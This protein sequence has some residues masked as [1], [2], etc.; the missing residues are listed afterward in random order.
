MKRLLV[1][2]EKDF[3][4][5]TYPDK[6]DLLI[7]DMYLS[8]PTEPSSETVFPLV[9]AKGV[10][11]TG[12]TLCCITKEKATEIGLVKTGEKTSSHAG[13]KNIVDVYKADLYL[14]KFKCY[15]KIDLAEFYPPEGKRFDVLIGMDILRDW[16]LSIKTRS[17]R[18]SFSLLHK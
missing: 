1:K 5:I 11:D 3:L 2:E 13:G 9:S 14:T 4:K 6:A 15:Q 17:G 16:D 18:T 7:F 10:I 12:S 8:L